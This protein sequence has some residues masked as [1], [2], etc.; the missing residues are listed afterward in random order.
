MFAGVADAF[1]Y[2][3]GCAPAPIIK[4]FDRQDADISRTCNPGYAYSVD[5]G[6]NNP[7]YMGTV[8]MYVGS[9]VGIANP[10]KIFAGQDA[11]II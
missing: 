3:K 5:F 9:I 1:C 6:S 4:D 7:G 10:S 11:T 2:I 8:A